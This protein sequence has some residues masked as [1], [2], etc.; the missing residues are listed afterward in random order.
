MT[1]HQFAKQLL[2]GPDLPI[3]VPAVV[4]YD[5]S[6]ESAKTPIVT[7]IRGER[8]DNDEPCDLLMISYLANT[9]VC[10]ADELPKDQ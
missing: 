2:E 10:H 6:D 9:E 5:D 7:K 3:F 1:A 8:T 4:E